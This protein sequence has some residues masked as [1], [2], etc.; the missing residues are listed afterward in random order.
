MADASGTEIVQATAVEAPAPLISMTPMDL[1]ARAVERGADLA[2]V[3]KLMDLAERHDKTQARKAFDEAMAAAKAE[4]P[5]IRKNRHVG[6]TSRRTNE[7]TSYSYEDLASIAEV[8]TPIL[9]QHG[10]S[11]RFRTA[12]PA[13]APVEVTCIISHKLGYSEEN[14]LSA[15]PDNSGK[16]NS[17][18]A[19]GS[20]LTYLQRM[21]LKA[22]LGLA[23]AADDDGKSAGADEAITDEQLTT[24]R[25]KIDATNADTEK[26][27]EM[28]G[29]DNLTELPQSR[30]AEAERILNE[31]AKLIAS[32]KKRSA[33]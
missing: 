20:T 32:K 30:F 15:P 14:T 22:A 7:D 4:I 24:L 10:L 12:S 9:A 16:K 23:A 3:E 28:F 17:I 19:I 5:V 26:L 33:E 21:T 2:M 13:N 25:Q 27:C 1:L 29:V 11:Y 8:V 31:R 18:Q 6:Y